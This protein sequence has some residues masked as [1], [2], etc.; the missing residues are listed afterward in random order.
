L[1]ALAAG[2]AA[3]ARLVST[4]YW[5]MAAGLRCARTC[6]APVLAV[7]TLIEPTD[8][9]VVSR[10]VEVNVPALEL[11][12]HRRERV[13]VAVVVTVRADLIGGVVMCETGLG[14][15]FDG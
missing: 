11:L 12:P 15:P 8:D 6:P 9:L 10:Q 5:L 7:D 1:K 4:R 2:L 14:P 13:A 3:A